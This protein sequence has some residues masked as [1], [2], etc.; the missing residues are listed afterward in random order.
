VE[1]DRKLDQA[2]LSVISVRWQKVAMIIAKSFERLK[3]EGAT[4]GFED[5]AARIEALVSVGHLESQG[6]LLEWRHS[7]VRMTS[8]NAGD[9][10]RDNGDSLSRLRAEGKG[11]GRRQ[12][13][14]RANTRAEVGRPTADRLAPYSSGASVRASDGSMIGIPSRTG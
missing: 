13:R 4:V 6:D 10:S 11:E 14:K 3:N 7:E 8:A 5:L 1:A 12:P 2:I 9:R